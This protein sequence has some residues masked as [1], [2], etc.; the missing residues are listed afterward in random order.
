MALNIIIINVREM[1]VIHHWFRGLNVPNDPILLSLTVGKLES[2]LFFLLACRGSS[3]RF[4]VGRLLWFQSTCK[5]KESE[6]EEREVS[7]LVK[8]L[9][10]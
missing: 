6:C 10:C 5:K 1:V 4:D 2:C 3:F 7:Q 8:S 9:V